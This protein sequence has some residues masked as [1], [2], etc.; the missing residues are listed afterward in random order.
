M[1]DRVEADLTVCAHIGS[2]LQ[3]AVVRCAEIVAPNVGSQLWD[4]LQSQ[5]CLRPY[6]FDPMVNVLALEDAAY[7]LA[8]AA[9]S[10][11]VGVFNIPGRDTLPL[12]RAIARSHRTDVRVPGQFVKPQ[13]FHFG[14]VLDGSRAA[15]ELDF[16]PTSAADWPSS[17]WRELFARL[18]KPSP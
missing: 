8:L 1:R 2:P 4:Y 3:I 6:G 10:K 11:A 13:R 7:A 18:E 17:W 14:A 9:R 5:L 16:V 15:K 12:S